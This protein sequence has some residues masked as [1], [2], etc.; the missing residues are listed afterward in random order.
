MRRFKLTF[1]IMILVT[2]IS[3][4][5][6][7]VRELVLANKYGASEIVDIYVISSNIPIALSSIFIAAMVSPYIPISSKITD[8]KELSSYTSGL[9]NF[10]IIFISIIYIFLIVFTEEIVKFFA[11]GFTAEK[12]DNTVEMTK[13]MLL[14]I[15]PVA[16]YMVLQNYLN[17]KEKFIGTA[18][19]G[20]ILNFNW[21]IG[22]LCSTKDNLFPM[23]VW[24]VLGY[25]FVSIFIILL[26]FNNGFRYRFIL[27]IRN[28]EFQNTLKMFFPIFIGSLVIQF[29]GIVD[30]SLA[31]LSGEGAIAILNY[32]S[33]L[34]YVI[35]GLLIVTFIT[36]INPKLAILYNKK[37]FHFKESV[38]QVINLLVI[39]LLPIVLSTMLFAE[40]IVDILFNRGAFTEK[41]I[42]LTALCLKFYIICLIPFGIRELIHKV[43]YISNNTIL[44]LLNN[45]IFV[46]LNIILSIVAIKV[47]ELN[48]VVLS[49]TIGVAYSIAMV[50]HLITAYKKEILCMNRNNFK[51]LL[52]II[53]INLISFLFGCFE[54]VYFNKFN[55]LFILPMSLILYFFQY[56]VLIY[57]FRKRLTLNLLNSR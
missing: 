18:F 34:M 56:I 2:A 10:I 30:R 4:V 55:N 46:G 5:L 45:I 31:S 50:L 25:V 13:I 9:L 38:T 26:A 24:N 3:N 48:F 36:Y 51:E 54:T 32:S 17:L 7:L 12:L 20:V 43:M 1:V 27:N 15:Y 19:I 44:S 35:S 39:L 29:N 57:L 47:F 33:R 21:I 53:C 6:G 37:N 40:G 42:Y 14:G 52:Y 22:I 8:E 28:L 49:L 16:I 23:G 41:D 11:L